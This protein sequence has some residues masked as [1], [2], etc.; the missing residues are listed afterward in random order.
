MVFVDIYKYRIL[1]FKKDSLWNLENKGL[2]PKYC[3]SICF[4]ETKS[5]LVQP[6]SLWKLEVETEK[7][8]T[9]NWSWQGSWTLLRSF[10]TAHLEFFH[11]KVGIFQLNLPKMDTIWITDFPGHLDGLVN[12][13]D[14][15]ISHSCE[16]ARAHTNFG[17]TLSLRNYFLRSTPA[18]ETT[19]K[20]MHTTHFFP[21]FFRLIE[22]ERLKLKPFGTVGKTRQGFQETRLML[23]KSIGNAGHF[24]PEHLSVQRVECG[25]F[26]TFRSLKNMFSWWWV[27]TQPGS[28]VNQS[29]KSYRKNH[30]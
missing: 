10:F 21:W 7:K 6:V 23:P 30:R 5:Q 27:S 17:I 24:G 4:Y 22:L 12:G 2:E 26:S 18:H 9:Q 13:A 25:L 15:N 11:S 29:R 8:K 14:L 3:F 19:R 16:Q 28:T 1:S 20:E